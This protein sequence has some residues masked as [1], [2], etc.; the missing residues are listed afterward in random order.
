MAAETGDP[1]EVR[2]L[3]E[4]LGATTWYTNLSVL[5]RAIN[6]IP[7][8]SRNSLWSFEIN[9]HCSGFHFQLVILFECTHERLSIKEQ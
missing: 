2:L 5:A 3:P 1:P 7:P 9:K 6:P 4:T 8:R